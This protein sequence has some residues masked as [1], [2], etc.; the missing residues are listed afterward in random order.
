MLCHPLLSAECRICLQKRAWVAS[1]PH[2]QHGEWHMPTLQELFKKYNLDPSAMPASGPR[3]KLLYQVDRMLK[4]LATYTDVRQLDGETTKYWWAPQAVNG[5][6]RV[7]MRYGGQVVDGTAFYVENSIDAVKQLIENMN[8]VITDS[9][10]AT[11]AEEEARR[12]K[13]S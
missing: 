4:E 12:A 10:D 11:W 2:L 13:K 9:D 3:A 1:Y 5:H 6:R 7:A 8:K